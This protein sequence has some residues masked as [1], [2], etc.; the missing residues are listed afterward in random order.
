MIK[1]NIEKVFCAESV[2]EKDGEKQYFDLYRWKVYNMRD[3]ISRDYRLMR[4]LEKLGVGKGA[5]VINIGSG[6][7]YDWVKFAAIMGADAIAS[8]VDREAVKE[9]KS[10]VQK[11]FL[12]RR[13]LLPSVRA[14]LREA[15][16]RIKWIGGEAGD[17][18]KLKPPRPAKLVIMEGFID[19]EYALGCYFGSIPLYSD[20]QIREFLEKGYELLGEDSYLLVSLYAREQDESVRRVESFIKSKTGI[21]YNIISFPL[22]DNSP[23][24]ELLS[25]VVDRLSAENILSVSI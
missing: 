8:D 18:A 17:I 19:P 24:S 3:M 22:S 13:D 11:E 4:F 2:F 12:L 1:E 6:R 16:R 7:V 14:K 23:W 10:K 15:Y 20:E 21:K 9:A 5:L 25:N